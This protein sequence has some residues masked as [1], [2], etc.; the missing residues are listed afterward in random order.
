MTYNTYIY[1]FTHIYAISLVAQ[2]E[3]MIFFNTPRKWS[4]E[5]EWFRDH[6]P[7]VADALGGVRV[8]TPNATSD[9]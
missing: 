3:V 7:T 4:T 5:K 1:A 9:D 2:F 8:T 6:N